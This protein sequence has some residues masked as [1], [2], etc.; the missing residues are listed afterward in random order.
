MSLSN[1]GYTLVY[2]KDKTVWSRMGARGARVRGSQDG[3]FTCNVT[4]LFKSILYL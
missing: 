1:G 3:R 4:W 2:N